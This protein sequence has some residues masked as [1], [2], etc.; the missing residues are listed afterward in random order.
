MTNRPP[1]HLLSGKEW[2]HNPYP[3]YAEL[4]S[5]WPVARVDW[6][7][8]GAGQWL[9][10]RYADILHVLTAAELSASSDL[11]DLGPPPPGGL[12]PED[13]AKREPMAGS[14]ISA[15]PPRHTR[16]RSPVSRAFTPQRVRRLRPRT[17]AIVESLLAEPVQ[18]ERFDLIGDVAAPLPGMVIAELLGVPGERI[19]EFRGWTNTWTAR[20]P[21]FGRGRVSDEVHAAV[22]N[23]KRCL[24]ETIDER[25]RHPKDDLI[26]A[27]LAA[28]E[29]ID[30]LDDRELVSSSLLLLGAG[31]DTTTNLIGNGTRTLIHHPEAFERL[32][33]DPEI[34]STA[35]EEL[36]R[37]D[38]PVQFISRAMLED[39]EV[40]GVVL[41]KA[42][43][44]HFSLGSSNR[45]PEQFEQPN[46]LRL[47]RDPN[48][49][50][51][52]AHGVH[53]CLGAHLARQTAEVAFLALTRTFKSLAI[54]PGGSKRGPNPGL[55]GYLR[56]DLDAYP[57]RAIGERTNYRKH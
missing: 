54:V 9:I 43:L 3:A 12:S 13:A 25:R 27:L 17:E 38:S 39:F 53:F 5:D 16:L 7:Q 8:Q 14:M 56:M 28:H 15:D 20:G 50:L 4:R 10:S 29:D 21:T 33:T 57:R 24:Q 48:R 32:A 19:D 11:A 2:F 30:P 26:S 41:P 51:S 31:F 44:V 52:F 1:Q 18:R 6:P 35:I 45:D 49:H 47:D 22:A 46:E 36:I 42:A 40:S 55:R 37:Y 23:L 34:A